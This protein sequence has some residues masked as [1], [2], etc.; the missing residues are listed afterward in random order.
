MLTFF[1]IFFKYEDCV[2]R[3]NKVAHH[4]SRPVFL[5]PNYSRPIFP[6]GLTIGQWLAKHSL[7]NS[8]LPLF[9]IWTL[10]KS[11]LETVQGQ[12]KKYFLW[13]NLV[14]VEERKVFFNIP[15]FFCCDPLK[16]FQ[17]LLLGCDP[18]VEKS[19]SRPFCLI[20]LYILLFVNFSLRPLL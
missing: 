7:L 20:K 13:T 2:P 6:W 4:W 17:V 14:L 15:L 5:N 9:Y 19:W 18:A 12:I 8:I 10:T 3:V 16:I 1:P 11:D